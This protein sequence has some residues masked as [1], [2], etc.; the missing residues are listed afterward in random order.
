[1]DWL[2][3]L[4]VQGT[5]KSSP[6]LQF[7]SIIS[8][9][10]SFLYGPALTSIHDYWKNHSF[11]CMDLFQQRKHTDKCLMYI[12]IF[13]N[14]K[15]EGAEVQPQLIQGIRRGDGFGE[16]IGYNSFI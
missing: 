8:L 13:T 15:M 4:A 6:T 12:Y 2:D 14:Q 11:D 7:K 3:L 10:L 16:F 1:M 9:V 5:L